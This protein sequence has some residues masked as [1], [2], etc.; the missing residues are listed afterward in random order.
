M[1]HLVIF[2]LALATAVHLVQADGSSI[3]HPQAP[4]PPPAKPLFHAP[5]IPINH[6]TSTNYHHGPTL[7]YRPKPVALPLPLPPYQPEPLPP[8]AVYH[9]KP[10]LPYKTYPRPPPRYI[11]AK[12]LTTYHSTKPTPTYH[13]NKPAP[14]YQPAKQEPKPYSYEYGVHDDYSGVHYNAG[15]VA[16]GSGAVQGSYTVALPDGRTQHVTYHADH[17][18]GFVAEVHYEGEAHYD[19]AP[20]PYNAP[21]PHPARLVPHVPSPPSSYHPQPS[22][23][24]SPLL[25]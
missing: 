1:L 7:V 12:P 3:S 8:P 5:S 23:P 18:N 15:Q 6:V 17:Y 20:A 14:I 9:P 22:Y 2:L 11:P 19:P 16:D 4:L 10:A 24:S 21:K 13:P 25:Y